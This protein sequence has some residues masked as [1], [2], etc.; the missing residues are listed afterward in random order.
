M[1][2]QQE[3]QRKVSF[4]FAYKPFFRTFAAE[5]EIIHR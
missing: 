2:K 1:G 5:T 3:M 4:L